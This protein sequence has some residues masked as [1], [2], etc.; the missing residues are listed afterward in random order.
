MPPPPARLGSAP[1][2]AE[3]PPL[4]S[5]RRRGAIRAAP[6]QPR[7]RHRHRHR[8]SGSPSARPPS[9][10]GGAGTCVRWPRCL[11]AA[12]PLRRVRRSGAARLAAP[13]RRKRVPF[14][15]KKHPTALS[16]PLPVPAPGP[17][18][19]AFLLGPPG[20][21][22]LEPVPLC[23]AL[24]TGLLP[25]P[26]AAGGGNAGAWSGRCLGGWDIPAL[27]CRLPSAIR[28]VPVAAGGQSTAG[29]IGGENEQ[30]NVLFC[31]GFTEPKAGP[32]PLQASGF[33][34]Q[35]CPCS[36]T[37]NPPGSLNERIQQQR[38]S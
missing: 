4:C 38:V 22:T 35:T 31:V 34:T 13:S 17:W 9:R 25:E 27:P 16:P 24:G 20:D 11:R 23:Q 29:A 8:R 5:P 15:Q 33:M 36:P 12:A 30:G 1:L 3:R 14:S 19:S 18:L 37:C 26:S 6:R 21:W 32:P 28:K 10:P 2:G 7:H